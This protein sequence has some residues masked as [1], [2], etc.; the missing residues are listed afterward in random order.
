MTSTNG[1]T[2]TLAGQCCN[3]LSDIVDFITKL[4]D[5]DLAETNKCCQDGT[6][7]GTNCKCPEEK[8][9]TK[10]C[11]WD[12][13]MTFPD[14]QAWIAS[15]QGLFTSNELAP[16][17][18][19][20]VT[21]LWGYVGTGG[22]LDDK[23]PLF[24]SNTG[25][26]VGIV[27]GV[28]AA[29]YAGVATIKSAV[30]LGFANSENA[31]YYMYGGSSDAGNLLGFIE[32]IWTIAYL[33]LCASFVAGPFELMYEMDKKYRLA[34]EADRDALSWNFLTFG[35]IE[36]I[37]QWGA[38][39]ALEQSASTLIGFFD[40]KGQNVDV[41]ALYKQIFGEDTTKFNNDSAIWSDVI[42][43]SMTVLFYYLV[44]A[45]ISGGSYY[46]VFQSVVPQV[47]A[48]PA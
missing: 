2:L 36:A 15:M 34:A 20:M 38:A 42:H 9:M 43:H 31:F 24:L 11:L 5:L 30:K 45:T 28:L 27:S 17:A 4:K 10:A 39:V 7:V 33:V 12:T 21:A 26:L 32:S 48:P 8:D 22:K 19:A 35:I 14:L 40:K 3:N 1:C 23:L 6:Q 37:G 29:M 41:V 44:A 18:I 16:A 47:E 25:G 46:Y 13:C